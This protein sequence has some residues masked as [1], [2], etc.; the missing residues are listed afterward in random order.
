MSLT[1]SIQGRYTASRD[2]CRALIRGFLENDP[3]V[4][5]GR[6]NEIF[7]DENSIQAFLFFSEDISFAFENDAVHCQ[8][9]VSVGGP[10]YY[11]HLV[12]LLER[13][14]EHC[15][16]E[17]DDDSVEDDS[18]YWHNRDFE[19]LQE[20][21]A[22]WLVELADMLVLN[23]RESGDA[24]LSLY[25]PM[26][27][28]P[29]PSG[30]FA[31]H[32]LGWLDLDFFL[33]LT[34]ERTAASGNERFFI[35]WD[36]QKTPAFFLNCAVGMMWCDCNWMS[37]LTRYETSI[38][39]SV[40][41]CL[42]YAWDEDRSLPFPI[43]EWRELAALSGSGEIAAEVDRRFPGTEQL[44]PGIGYRRGD[45]IYILSGGWCITMPGGLHAG[46]ESGHES[47]HI[48]WDRKKV[49]RMA[50]VGLDQPDEIDVA[51]RDV[52][53]RITHGLDC[54]DFAMPSFSPLLVRVQH[55]DISGD[56][57]P[58]KHLTTFYCVAHAG[59]VLLASFY[60]SDES[61]RLWAENIAASIYWIDQR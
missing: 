24:Q 21:M 27:M 42:E 8:A 40:L 12:R 16:L 6:K 52:L 43:A 39:S 58:F 33:R 41:L 25:M 23:Y 30:R 49:V 61:D 35:W 45:I 60:Y 56:I 54:A 50:R 47:I 9:V 7:A 59:E 29:V 26:I 31:C 1:V 19:A 46:D 37:P 44:Q 53:D 13:M 34:E 14:A 3:H 38:F 11:A 20:A 51:S 17:W 22:D 48:F 36:E 32:P 18:G 2:E 10:G 4:L 55:E 15:G 5:P 57:M 28:L